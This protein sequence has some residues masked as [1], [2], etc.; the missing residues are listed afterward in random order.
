MLRWVLMTA[1]LS[2]A[3][4]ACAQTPETLL[5]GIWSNAAQVAAADPALI[6]PPAAGHPY[7]WIDLQHASFT[8]VVI[9]ALPGQ[10]VHLAWRSG[11]P[12]GP[13]SRQRI[14]LFR[15]LADGGT[16][17][18]FYTPRQPEAMVS[19]KPGAVLSL[20]LDDLI[21]YGAACSLPVTATA[22]GFSASIPAGCAI[23]ARSGRTMTLSARIGWDGE[24][25]RYQEAGTL[26]DGSYAFKV[27]GGPAYEFRKLK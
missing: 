21:S 19:S 8:P 15:R 11:G 7:E 27:P 6:R 20:T 26:A 22:S 9:P 24:T 14:W 16:A 25:L 17:M 13:I 3:G 18:D 5:A 1:L 10:A 12:Q 4:A 23:T 2:G